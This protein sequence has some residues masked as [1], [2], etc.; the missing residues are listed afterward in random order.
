[1]DGAEQAG[2]AGLG[3]GAYNLFEASRIIRVPYQKLRRWA[4]GYWYVDEDI[5]RYSAAVV[6]HAAG[7][8]GEER[9]LSFYELM[10]LFVIVF[11]RSEGVSMQVVR[12]ARAVAQK[13]Y[14]TEY[15]F[16]MQKLPTDGKRIFAELAE[17]SALDIPGKRLTVELTKSQ[18]AMDA[19][20]GPFFKELDFDHGLAY[21]YWP[22]GRQRPVILDA[23]RAFGRPIVERRG[24]PTYALFNMVEGG[25]ERNLVAE[26]YQV[27]RDELDTAIEYELMLRAA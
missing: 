2:R 9:V 14:G 21:R 6:P 23:R 8:E 13:L 26:W 5:E 10:E 18:I 27:S 19:V 17:S 20:V 12:A 25:E 16:A 7:D 11:Y 1:M 4:S 3:V 24:V 22:L 15:P